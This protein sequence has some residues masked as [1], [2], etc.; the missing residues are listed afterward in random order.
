AAIDGERPI[1]DIVPTD[2]HERCPLIIGSAHEVLWY[3]QLRR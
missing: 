1:L 3:Q 2:I